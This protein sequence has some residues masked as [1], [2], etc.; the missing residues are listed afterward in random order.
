[1]AQ[2]WCHLCLDERRARLGSGVIFAIDERRVRRA[3]G[4]LWLTPGHVVD[5]CRP[6]LELPLPTSRWRLRGKGGHVLMSRQLSAWR[7][8]PP[9]IGDCWRHWLI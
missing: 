7:E 8:L 5:D 9:L 4:W 2:L 6:Y 1:V 3:G